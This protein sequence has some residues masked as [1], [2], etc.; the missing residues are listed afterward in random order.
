MAKAIWKYEFVANE[1]TF[2]M[3]IGANILCVQSQRDTVCIW[4]LVVTNPDFPAE[5]RSFSVYRTRVQTPNDPGK[6]I[7]TTQVFNGS[8][9][10]HIFETT[11]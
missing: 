2:Q 10:W 3:P 5:E 6:Y 11:R 9:V 1:A 7:G 8:F 4:A